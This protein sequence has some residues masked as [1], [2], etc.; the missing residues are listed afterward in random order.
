MPTSSKTLNSKC[1]SG[2]AN[3]AK[4]RVAVIK[5]PGGA[6]KLSRKN[7]DGYQKFVGIYG[8][9][10]LPFIKVND[11]DAGLE[12]LQSPIVKFLTAE[13]AEGILERSGGRVRRLVVL[14]CR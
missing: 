13:M 4:G 11:R 5:V 3:D 14:R 8:A 9:K 6:S 12:G 1:F 7:I 2:P 10:G